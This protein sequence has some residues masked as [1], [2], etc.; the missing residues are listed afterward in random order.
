MIKNKFLVVLPSWI[1]DIVISQS[2]LKK[3]KILHENSSIDVVVRSRFKT[4]VQ[5]MPEIDD[6]YPLDIP[7]GKLGLFK[8]IELSKKLKNKYSCSII[9]TNS[10]KSA[11]VPWLSNIPKRIGYAREMR[12]VLLTKS[13]NYNKHE[14][15]MVNRYLKL[16]DSKYDMSIAPSLNLDRAIKKG[17]LDRFKLTHEKKIVVLCPDAEFGPAKRWPTQHWIELIKILNKDG[18]KPIILGEN[19]SLAKDISSDDTSIKHML[20]GKTDLLEA[21]YI[22]SSAAVVISNDS[23]LM[24]IASA[25]KSKK[26]VALFGS[27]SPK[28]TAPLSSEEQNTV[29]YKSLNCSPCFKRECPLRHFDC[30]TKITP[31]EV[32]SSIPN[33]LLR[34]N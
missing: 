3:L 13:L 1:G 27:S 11:L 7:H 9:L 18:I 32:Y 15:S 16:V 29:I 8:R 31:I 34:A 21:V 6:I 10:F 17:V 25:V 14:S 19:T 4:L 5:L 26:L 2:L 22:L 20:V 28:Y 24:H 30:M 33:N 12:K 23:G